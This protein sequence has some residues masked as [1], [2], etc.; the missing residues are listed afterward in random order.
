VFRQQT[1]RKWMIQQES[2]QKLS[3]NEEENEYGSMSLKGL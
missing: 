2:K 3:K 1:R